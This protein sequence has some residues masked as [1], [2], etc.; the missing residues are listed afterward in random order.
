MRSP[1][2]VRQPM[3]LPTF[4]ICGAKKAGTTSLC[5]YLS[6]HPNVIVSRPKETGFFHAHFD[7]GI[8]WFEKHFHHYQGQSAIGE[9]SVHTMYSREAPRRVHEVIPNARLIFLLRNPIERLYSHYFYD[10]R[11]GHLDPSTSFQEVIYQRHKPLHEK[12]VR[13][14]FYDEQLSRFEPFFEGQMLILLTSDLHL[15][16]H[17]TVQKAL[18]FV[19][20]DPSQAPM[21]FRQHNATRHLHYRRVYSFLRAAW[22]PIRYGIETLFP[23]ITDSVRS[24]V[25]SLLSQD[26]RPPMPPEDRR[27]LQN[28]YAESI[29]NIEHR[30]GRTLSHWR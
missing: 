10:L 12:M 20:V 27:Y 1:I 8:D 2:S 16:T 26:N 11:C 3:P 19:G 5:R 14:G 17:D 24:S 13:M 15:R 9:G 23:A 4:L 18:S 6:G 22:R 28:L 7:R 25:R 30:I 21:E 29:Q